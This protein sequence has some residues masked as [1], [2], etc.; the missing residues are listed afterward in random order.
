MVCRWV[1][2]VIG[3]L[4][5]S[6]CDLPQGEGTPAGGGIQV[7]D[8]A[9]HRVTFSQPAQRIVSLVPATT[10]WLFAIGAGPQLVA[11]SDWCDYPEQA[12]ALPSLGDGINP[13]LEAIVN[14]SPDMVVLYRSQAN[15]TAANRLRTLGIPVLLLATDRLGDMERQIEMLGVVTNQVSAAESVLVAYRSRLAG[16]HRLSRETPLSVL[17]LAWDQPAIVL[18]RGSF[19][20]E[21]LTLAGARNAFDDVAASSATISIEA[22]AERDPDLVLTTEDGPP[23]ITNRPEWHVVSAIREGRFLRISGSQFNRPSPRA[24]E[25]VAALAEALAAIRPR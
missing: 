6:S 12:L 4:L 20:S 15:L 24:P 2:S 3:G 13:N 10:E 16:A 11:R 23:A 8:D 17:L 21:L 19:L 25:A 5:L 22:I 14:A 1:M 18:G 7:V 9:G